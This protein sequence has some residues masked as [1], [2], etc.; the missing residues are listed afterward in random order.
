LLVG[1][2]ACHPEQVALDT[3]TR[4]LLL[5]SGDAQRVVQH[6]RLNALIVVKVVDRDG[7]TLRGVSVT[8]L[9]ASGSSW[10]TPGTMPTDGLGMAAW[11]G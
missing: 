7:N 6:Q 10:I 11:Q 8:F 5:V 2:A 9:A 3:P 1:L 4:K